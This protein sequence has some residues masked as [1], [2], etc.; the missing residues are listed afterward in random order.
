VKQFDVGFFLEAII[1]RARAFFKDELGIDVRMDR[2]NME[3]IQK[4]ELRFMTSLLVLEGS[5]KLFVAFSFEK[6]LIERAFQVYSED[7]EVIE[8][9]REGY[10]EETAGDVINIIVG[11]ATSRLPA[12]GAAL[13]IS[14]PIVISEAKS[15]FR[16]K[17]AQFYAASLETDYG[18]MDVYCIGP[19]ELFADLF[20]RRPSRDAG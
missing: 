3:D 17:D 5:S 9:E 20:L 18:R 12:E 15:I 19:K 13:T 1:E 10:V 4:I 7:I 6:P 8:E 11:N 16:H 2:R 14:P